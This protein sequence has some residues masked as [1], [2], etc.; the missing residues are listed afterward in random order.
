[1]TAT[2]RVL[3]R[4]DGP[5]MLVGHSWGG[6]VITEAG[7]HPNVAGLVYVAALAPDAGETTGQV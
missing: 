3:D 1:V 6:T 5:T 2:R 7:M 4:Q